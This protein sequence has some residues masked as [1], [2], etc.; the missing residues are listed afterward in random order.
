MEKNKEQRTQQGY[1][2]SQVTEKDDTLN[3]ERGMKV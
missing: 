2:E 3:K 1:Q